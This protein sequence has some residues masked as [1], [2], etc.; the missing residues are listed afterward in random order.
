MK[1]III[2]KRSILSLNLKKKLNTS[3]IISTKDFKNLKLKTKSNLIIN[4]F[5][6]SHKLSTITKYS[7][8]IYQSLYNLSISLDTLDKSKI[9]KIIYTS[10]SS[11]YGLQNIDEN[12]VGNN[13]NIYS[14]AKFLA[15]SLI[16][17]FCNKNNIFY[18][19]TR[20]FNLYG[21]NDNFSI[22]FHLKLPH[23]KSF[24]NNLQI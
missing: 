9:N 23:S 13:R 14:A 5:Y 6:P 8:F 16:K 12:S 21:E 2:G 10:S 7:V 11:V 1:N 24:K 4:L 22:Y 15:E 19:I 20:V 18:S 17:N 3:K